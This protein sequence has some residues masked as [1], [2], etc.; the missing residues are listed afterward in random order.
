MPEASFFL[1]RS[2]ERQDVKLLIQSIIFWSLLGG[3]NIGLATSNPSHISAYLKV[4]STFSASGWKMALQS[5]ETRDKWQMYS[6]KR[7]V[8]DSF[9]SKIKKQMEKS[10]PGKDLCI[11]YGS[12]Y[13]SMKATG[14]GEIAAPVGP[15]F[16][17][18]KRVF[19]D[20]V[21]VVDE[22]RPTMISWKHG[23]K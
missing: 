18:C 13:K 17:A 16:T 5:R 14:K 12:A 19:K 4:Y 2:K 21:V 7:H 9:Y 20:K 11:A 23:T 8:M 6:G 10:Y 15:M 3:D 22:F 1:Y